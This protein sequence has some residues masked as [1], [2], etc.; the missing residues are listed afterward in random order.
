MRISTRLFLAFGALIALMVCLSG[1]SIYSGTSIGSTVAAMLRS[2]NAE[3]L[4]QRV[5]KAV[6]QGRLRVWMYVATGD[7][8]NFDKAQAAFRSGHQTVDELSRQTAATAEIARNVQQAASGTQEISANI[9]GVTRAVGETGAAASQ[10][11]SSSHS[12]ARETNE[13]E[14]TL[15]EFLEDVRAA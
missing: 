6:L 7:E 15:D 14:K 3:V 11:L 1:F 4:D 8:T 5:E 12:L 13:L 10:V 2:K 9:V